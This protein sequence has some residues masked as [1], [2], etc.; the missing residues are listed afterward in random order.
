M[1]DSSDV[2][3]VRRCICYEKLF[4]SSTI[5]LRELRREVPE[6]LRKSKNNLFNSEAS[7]CIALRAAPQCPF[8]H[9]RIFSRNLEPDFTHCIYG[10]PK[11]S[12]R[13]EVTPAVILCLDGLTLAVY[14]RMNITTVLLRLW[15][16]VYR[17]N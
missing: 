8:T 17:A 6:N 11:P 4:V 7:A 9:F 3:K 16:R 2:F 13:R 10:A 1:P 5:L 14:V 15:A 12:K